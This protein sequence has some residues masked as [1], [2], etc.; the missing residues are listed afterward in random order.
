[1]NKKK[2]K[3]YISLYARVFLIAETAENWGE[4][5]E[6]ED[7]KKLSKFC[8]VLLDDIEYNARTDLTEEEYDYYNTMVESPVR[9]DYE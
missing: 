7:F 3:L 2:A 5:A 1:M 8:K 9:W 4:N 6:T